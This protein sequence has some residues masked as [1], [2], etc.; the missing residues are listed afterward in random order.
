MSAHNTRDVSFY[1]TTKA[2]TSAAISAITQ[3][4][5]TG[6]SATLA[7]SVVTGDVVVC[8]GT[9]WKSVDG[10]SILSDYN[11]GTGKLLGSNSSLETGSAPSAGTIMHYGA[12]DMTK[13]CPSEITDNTNTP[14]TVGVG[15]FCDPEAV[16]AS[17]VTEAG[18]V[19]LSGYV[20]ICT[21]D[22]QALYEAY[23]MKDQRYMKIDLGAAGGWLVMP[24][25]ALSMNWSIPL[26]GAVGYTIEFAKGSAT[27]HAF[28]ASTC[29]TITRKAPK[30]APS[31]KE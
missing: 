3:G 11:S 30:T 2:P 10:V 20:D 25:T 9:G 15:T 19:S 16:I 6:F 14:A 7:G 8:S 24:V 23:E 13:L 17:P 28:D 27:K 5:P 12:D 22:Y 4:N 31:A 21:Y 26:E 18:A 29:T 1:L